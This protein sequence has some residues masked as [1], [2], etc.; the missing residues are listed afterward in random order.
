MKFQVFLALKLH[1]CN[2]TFPRPLL[3]KIKRPPTLQNEPVA[4]QSHLAP[5][6]NWWALLPCPTVSLHILQSVCPSPH[7]YIA[8]PVCPL[9]C[10]SIIHT[11]CP[12][13]HLSIIQPICL[14][15][16][17][18][19]IQPVCLS[20]HQSV[21]QTVSLLTHLYVTQPIHLSTCPSILYTPC[22]MQFTHLTPTMY[23]HLVF[24]GSLLHQVCIHPCDCPIIHIKANPG[25][26]ILA[27]HGP[28]HCPA[29]FNY[30]Q[31]SG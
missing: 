27:Y 9:T 21:I 1:L 19:V 5:K 24:C 31:Q 6:M 2:S 15:T 25:Q 29:P 14:S 30:I 3:P 22:W 17:L 26:L 4:S 13:N 12:S 11:D 28:F 16:H 7:L 18:S 8:Q 23:N 10:L 20:T